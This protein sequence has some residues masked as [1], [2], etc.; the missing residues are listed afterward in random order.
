MNINPITN[1]FSPNFKAIKV[2]NTI[3]NK[4]GGE[5]QIYKLGRED[6]N[7]L[8]KI[9]STI[10]IKDRCEKLTEILQERWQNI[11]NYCI[12][13]AGRY[14]NT[15]YAA[16]NDDK[17]CCLMTYSKDG[18]SLFLDAISA[19]PN[20]NGKRIPFAGQVLF[21]QLFKDALVQKAKS[22]KLDA[23]QD[24]PIDVI[25]KYEKLGFKKDPTTPI[26]SAMVC[27]KYKI[28]EQLKKLSSTI[29]YIESTSEKVNLEDTIH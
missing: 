9:L 15:T 21:S 29:N 20:K 8:Q 1:N 28:E 16:I 26:Y 10:K 4:T 5:I 3:N 6:I 17:L 27:N 11:L 13:N 25:S 22:I 14:G 24:G 19:I 2:A 12:S 23:V 18:N 7:F